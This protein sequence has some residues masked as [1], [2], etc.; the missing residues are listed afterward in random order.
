MVR[1][2]VKDLLVSTTLIAVGVGGF[3]CGASDTIPGDFPIWLASG[4]CVG[5]GLL[6]PFRLATIGAVIGGFIMF[7]LMWFVMSALPI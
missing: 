4:P 6:Y 7:A 5:A 2:S 3:I 1:F